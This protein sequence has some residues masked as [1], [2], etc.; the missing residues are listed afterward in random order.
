MKFSAE[1][2]GKVKRV[3][4]NNY[5]P[6][7]D[8]GFRGEKLEDEFV[9]NTS[10]GPLSFSEE[11]KSIVIRKKL[12][13]DEKLL[14]YGEKAF[15]IDRKRLRLTMWNNDPGGYRRGTDPLYCSI[16]FFISVGR[17]TC[18]Y[19]VNATCKVIFDNGMSTYNEMQ[20]II[21]DTGAE[22]YAFEG[23]NIEETLEL[24]TSLTGKPFMPPM[25]ALGHQISRYSYFPEGEVLEVVDKYRSLVPVSSIYLDIDYM[26]Q[27][28]IFTWNTKHFPDPA[29]LSRKLHER[30]VKLITIVDP[31]VKAEQGYKGFRKG[32]GS[33]VETPSNELF[34][35]NVWP[36]L[37]AF[38]DFISERGQRFWKDEMTDFVTS[39]QLDGIWLDMNEPSIFMQGKT[40]PEDLVHHNGQS[41][42]R[43]SA[44]H[45]AYAY[46]EAK[47][48]YEALANCGLEPFILTRSGFAGI[49]K[50]AA[51]WTGDNE[52]SWDDL[53]LQIS[54]V[55]SLGLS[56]MPF[57]GCD[58]GG[59][60]G[61]TEP[62]L[63]ARYY[64]MAAFFPVYRNHKAKDGSDQELFSLPEKYRDMAV[65]AVKMRYAFLPYLYS[66][67]WEAHRKGHPIVRPLCYDFQEDQNSFRIDDQYMVGPSLMYAPII[68]RG[69]YRREVYLP[70]GKWYSW[71]ER[72]QLD[73]GKFVTATSEFPL[74]VKYDSIV[75]MEGN[76]FI[77]YGKANFILYTGHEIRLSSQ[78]AAFE[79]S[80]FMSAAELFY[81]GVVFKNASSDGECSVETSDEGTRI[82]CRNFTR[83]N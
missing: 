40:M 35:G 55:T 23:K 43:H 26:E 56:G 2:K 34:L 17:R 41:Y 67:A 53:R 75:P 49:Q 80:E 24:Y 44:A 12:S 61:R 51:I 20:I 5:S 68:E 21:E 57:A 64:Q 19:L 8:F 4:I 11:G 65:R 45:N 39:A 36:G 72:Q 60:M 15:E 47:A 76:A 82:R 50:Y 70:K 78:H 1:K 52:S 6:L 79:S 81:P 22:I 37:C 3:R 7:I 30:N 69:Q 33:F 16:P 38:P 25:W 77:V 13:I 71:F 48:T 74:Y 73:G 27:F 66:L 14:G 62:E 83:I 59:F 54:M 58:L 46:Y 29:R 42:V 9:L 10:G 32:L 31:G 18:G 63:I 28:K